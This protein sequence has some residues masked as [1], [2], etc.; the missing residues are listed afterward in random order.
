MSKICLIDGSGFIFRAFHALP[1]LTTKDG[2]PVNAVY[3]FA[4]SIMALQ[5]DRKIEYMAVIFDASRLTFRQNIYK[6]YKAQRPPAPEELIPQFPLIRQMTEALNIAS[7]EM[8]GFEADDLIATYVKLAASKNIDVEIVSSDKDLMQLIDDSKNI[9]MYDALKRKIITEKEV[10]EKFAV[11]PKQVV[12]VQALMGDSIDNVPGVKGVGP[13][14]AAELINNFTNLE[15]IYENIETITKKALKENLVRDKDMA[16]ISRELVKLK[17]DINVD[18]PLERFEVREAD[19]QKLCDFLQKLSFD[20]LA[21]K[22]ASKHRLS[23]NKHTDDLFIHKIGKEEISVPQNFTIATKTIDS[24]SELKN[25]ATALS[26]SRYLPML[27]SYKQKEIISVAIASEDAN[28]SIIIAEENLFADDTV[29]SEKT[30]FE[31]FANI[32]GNPAILKISYDIKTLL[33]VANKYNVSINSYD[34][35]EQM[36]YLVDG[37]KNPENKLAEIIQKHLFI[38]NTEITPNLL[39]D[40]Y[41]IY[42]N[43]IITN[44]QKYLYEIFDKPLLNVLFTMEKIGIKIDSNILKTLS[45]EFEATLKTIEQNIFTLSGS[46][47]NVGSPKQLGEVLF[48]KME[49][50]GKKNKSGSYKTD[51]SVLEALAEEG[52]EIA[53]LILKWRQLAKLKNTYTDKLPEKIDTTSGRIHTTYLP[54]LTSTGRLSSVEPNLQNIPIRSDE[55]KN[56]RKAFVAKSGYKIISLDYSQIELRIL[57]SIGNVVS[58]KN[59]FLIGADIHKA[60]A[61]EM[62][63]IPIDQVDS[64][65]RRQA[66][67]INFGIIYGQTQ[68]GLAS[69]LGITKTQAQNYINSYFHKYPEIQKYMNDT[70]AFAKKYGF[71]LTFFNRK[72]FV[73]NIN[74][75]NANIRN[76]NERAAINAR[77]QGTGAD[78]MRK[79]MIDTHKFLTKNNIDAN[80]LLQIHDEIIIEAKEDIATDIANKIQQ[81]MENCCDIGI[82]L[83]VDFGIADNWFKA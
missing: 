69:S 22:V 5:E 19:P 83:N 68:Y 52:F 36:S 8:D 20:S 40:L 61:S 58:L 63:N 67:A 39:M 3:G 13:K 53:N 45:N 31:T 46:E 77:I 14:G 59:A 17:D 26:Q 57:A 30:F 2:T 25:V 60:T 76:F 82:K 16:F 80:I 18:V 10:H 75:S 65:H 32:L 1:P 21:T 37:A 9:Y 44:K 4:K 6:E 43:K 78:V 34:D 62:F 23:L 38:E 24:L 51:S 42:Y 33:H 50:K 64:N 35:I 70:V 73:D 81:I 49:L 29:I 79:A 48:E 11:S 47:F 56:I 12:E 71:V 27:V 55:G 72:C 54:C 41:N 74:S 66:K 7:I 15:G 28:Y